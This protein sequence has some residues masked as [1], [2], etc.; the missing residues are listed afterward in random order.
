MDLLP[1]QLMNSVL[2]K[3]YSELTM[4]EDDRLK[5][6][7]DFFTWITPGMPYPEDNLDFLEQG[8]VAT[9][10]GDDDDGNPIDEEEL[11][12]RTGAAKLRMYQ[13]AEDLAYIMDFVPDASGL[14]SGSKRMNINTQIWNPASRLSD[15]YKFVLDQCQVVQTDTSESTKEKIERVR[16]ILQTTK[17]VTTYDDD[18]Q[19]IQAEVTVDSPLTVAYKEKKAIYDA[20]FME[21][22]NAEIKALNGDG[23]AVD[24]FALNETILRSK[25]RM[26]ANDWQANGY[27]NLYERATSFL[28]QV[29]S[30]DLNLLMQGYREDMEFSRVANPA[31]P[32]ARF[33]FTRLAPSNFA[34]SVQG[35]TKFE[36]SSS[37][38]ESHFDRERTNWGGKTGLNLGKFNIGGSARKESTELTK[39]VEWG[40]FKLSFYMAQVPLLKSWFHPHIFDSQFWRFGP[41][42]AAT[43]Q[44]DVLSDG[45]IPPEG[46]L[47]AYPTTAIF[48][49]DLT[50]TFDTASRNY[51]AFYSKIKAKGGLSWGPFHLGGDYEKETTETNSSGSN[52]HEGIKVDGMQLIGFRCHLLSKSPNPLPTIEEDM[53]A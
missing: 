6:A 44:N 21:Y 49:K 24:F 53:W 28:D 25:V 7:N 42:V 41:N 17:T 35:W 36:F 12:R 1:E 34:S 11:K 15:I 4:G 18:F 40:S 45:G 10:K 51:D 37:D 22:R 23:E 31:S 46:Q 3:L 43:G 9:Y 20:A 30:G 32:G 39:S 47:P 29:A 27:K 48:I 52:R 5:S 14:E 19:E 16:G 50:M 8:F 26:A 33:Y 2:G 38:F 13:Q